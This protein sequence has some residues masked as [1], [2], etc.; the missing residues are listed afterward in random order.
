VFPAPGSLAPLAGDAGGRRYFRIQGRPGRALLLVVYPEVRSVSQENWRVVRAG[1]EAVGLKVP[2]L[3]AESPDA[4]AALIE[5]LGDT[6]L[7]SEIRRADPGSR[8]RLL[9]EA[10]A[11]LD[12]LRRIDP[13]VA[14]RNPA[15]D[16]AFFGNEL[17]HTR[18]WALE[19]DGARPLSDADAAEWETLAGLLAREAADVSKNG[20]P[21]P[22]HRDFHA[23][24]L[25]RVKDGPLAMIDFQDLRMGPRDYDG[26]SL[27]FE[28]AGA[29]CTF[30]PRDRYRDAVLLQRAWKVLG[31]FEKMLLW[32]R[33]V[34]MAHR[35]TATRVIRER[36][37]PAGP[38]APLR[39]FLGT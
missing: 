7:A 20:Q 26:V 1:L 25:I 9:D 36:T 29:D 19:R 22:V 27:R 12:R 10:E 35:D 33:P 6:D 18:R 24:N 13:A 28:R 4:G 38:F 31:T 17:A 39:R 16:S 11:L 8:L 23:N 14:L 37:D 30:P 15:F 34:Y 32:G 2:E 21:V 5:D 3:L